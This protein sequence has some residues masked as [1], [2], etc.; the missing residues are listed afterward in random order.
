MKKLVSLLLCSFLSAATFAQNQTE[1]AIIP[2]PVSITRGTGQFVL[3]QNITIEAGDQPE[4]KQTIAFLKDRLSVPTG[5]QVN[6]SNASPDATIRLVLNKTADNAIGKE[7]Y[8]LS[9][10]P[11][12][13]VIKANEPAGLF[14]GV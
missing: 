7:G 6:V 12:N 4:L 13:I 11:T 5:R 10:T 9:V 2:E 3:P 8:Q 1:V 14:Y